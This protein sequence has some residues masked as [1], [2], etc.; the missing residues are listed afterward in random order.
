L[1]EAAVDCFKSI[2][3]RDLNPDNRGQRIYRGLRR[4]WVNWQRLSVFCTREGVSSEPV[5]Q[6]VAGALKNFINQETAE[7]A[8]GS[9]CSSVNCSREQLEDLV[10]LLGLDRKQLPDGWENLCVCEI[11]DDGWHC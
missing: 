6:E 7:I 2:I 9:G 11:A 4:C 1:Q 5:R 8:S 3:L 10:D